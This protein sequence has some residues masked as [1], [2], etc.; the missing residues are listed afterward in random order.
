MPFPHDLNILL[1]GKAV[2]GEGDAATTFRLAVGEGDG[3]VTVM[4]NAGKYEDGH[5]CTGTNCITADR[6]TLFVGRTEGGGNRE[7]V[8]FVK[9]T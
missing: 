8:D 5:F 1:S 4:V 3:A 6:I 7:P 2:V 9:T